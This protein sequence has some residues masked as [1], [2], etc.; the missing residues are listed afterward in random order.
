MKKLLFTTLCLGT[1]MGIGNQSLAFANPIENES[2]ELPNVIDNQ[3]IYERSADFTVNITVG[4]YGQYL[5]KTFDVNKV[6][7]TDHNAIYVKFSPTQM[8][9]KYTIRVFKNGSVIRTQTITGG[10]SPTSFTVEN[11]NN[12]SDKY[13]VTVNNETEKT[14]TGSLYVNTRLN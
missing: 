11:C 4:A 5:S 14:L 3:E 9:G 12:P 1:L 8:S 7:G 10:S 2:S 13:Y 6:I